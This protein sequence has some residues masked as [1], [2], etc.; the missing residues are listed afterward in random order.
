[1]DVMLPKFK[2]KTKTKLKQLMMEAGVRNLFNDQAN[3]S[4]ISDL[5]I[6]VTD[7]VQEAFIEVDEEGTEA[8]AATGVI[9]GLRIA[10]RRESFI[11]NRPFG[12]VL[13]D[14][15]QNIPLFMGKVKHL[16]VI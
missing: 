6:K 11:M 3:L 15:N 1:M 7:A 8:A 14:F 2:L 13:Y 9:L 12:F 16:V 4:G 5:P 10:S